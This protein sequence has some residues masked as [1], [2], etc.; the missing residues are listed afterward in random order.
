MNR[1][2]F[3]NT[4]ASLLVS[5][6]ITL[7]LI[8]PMKSIADESQALSA[9]DVSPEEANLNTMIEGLTS[10]DLELLIP[11]LAI[12]FVFGGPVVIVVTLVTQ[13]FRSQKGLAEFRRECIG[14]LIDA[15]KDVPESLL[16]FDDLGK[17][18][19]PERDL[20]RGVKNI[21]L[22]I[23]IAIFLAAVSSLKVGTF[24]LILVGLGC[25]QLLSWKLTSKTA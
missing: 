2:R 4:I 14:K 8:A 13:H 16:Y 24:G 3:I 5:I 9:T 21:G 19:A 11:I 18:R 7:G 12:I 25:A 22:G 17:D 20:S 15:G 23:G 1:N 6:T 10:G